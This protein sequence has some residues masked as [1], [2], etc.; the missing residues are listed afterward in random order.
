MSMLHPVT[1]IIRTTAYS[2]LLETARAAMDTARLAIVRGPVGIGKTFAL[3]QIEEELSQGEDRVFLIEAPSDKSKSIQRFY[4]KALFD[5]GMSGHGGADPFE[6]FKGYMLRGYPFRRFGHRPRI[7]LIVDECQ[8]L[9]PNI[10]E[11]L[12]NA[13]DG[14]QWARDFDPEAPAFG[15]LLVG[16]HHFLTK[17]GRSV[18]ATFDALLSRCPLNIDLGRPEPGEYAALA[19]EL[20]PAE[21]ELQIRVARHGA[22]MG[23][24]RE[25]AEAA[26]LARHYA[27]GGKVSPIHLEK[28]ILLA[29]GAK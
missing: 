12:R 9:A 6:V 16:N 11:T 22:K 7:L 26:A 25:L 10:L 27:G 29:T 24:L 2:R 5:M 15:L 17:G 23:N 28:A 13:Y 19:A 20:F 1:P 4:Q 14:G 3:R 18:M 21:E 8:R